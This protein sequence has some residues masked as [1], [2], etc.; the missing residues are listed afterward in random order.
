MAPV[1]S[2]MIPREKINKKR[3]LLAGGEDSLRQALAWSFLAWNEKEGVAVKAE[4][5]GE[6]E[7]IPEES[8]READYIVFPGLCSAVL[9][10]DPYQCMAWLDD[11]FRLLKR[12]A[13]LS[14]KARLILLSDGRSFGKLKRDS[15]LPNTRRGRRTLWK[16]IF[17]PSISCR[18]RRGFSS[19]GQK[20]IEGS[21]TFCGPVGCTGRGFLCWITRWAGWPALQRQGKREKSPFCRS[22]LLYLHPRSSDG[23]SVCADPVPGRKGISRDGT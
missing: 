2:G 18:R 1:R 10:Q 14:A 20:R 6:G 19:P 17:P 12:T 7:E 5:Y 15:L 21:L 22:G 4:Q 23:S 11:W 3:V 9:P 8:F 16:R 13:D